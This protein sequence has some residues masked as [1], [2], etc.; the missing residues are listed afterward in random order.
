MLVTFFDVLDGDGYCD[1]QLPNLACPTGQY[2]VNSGNCNDS[3]DTIY[4]GAPEICDGIDN[5][6]GGVSILLKKM[7]MVMGLYLAASTK[8]DGMV[9][10]K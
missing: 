9:F 6:C 7:E 4:P 3:D 10:P 1:P 8:E 5:N 2:T